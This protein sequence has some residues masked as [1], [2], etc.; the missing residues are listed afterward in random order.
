MGHSSSPGEKTWY[1]VEYQGR[2]VDVGH[3]ELLQITH[4]SVLAI[5]CVKV[6]VCLDRIKS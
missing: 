4:F 5:V 1:K 3:A 6:R 2:T